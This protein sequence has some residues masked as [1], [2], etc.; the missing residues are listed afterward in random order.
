EDGFFNYCFYSLSELEDLINSKYYFYGDRD[1]NILAKL[2]IAKFALNFD[3]PSEVLA[4]PIE[5]HTRHDFLHSSILA[6]HLKS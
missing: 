6:K 5:D 2:S 4:I 3:F 1:F